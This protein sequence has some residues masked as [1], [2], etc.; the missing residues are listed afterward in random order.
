MHERRFAVTL[1]T[2]EDVPLLPPGDRI[3][4]QQ[5]ES[6]GASVRVA[7]WTDRD[8]D[9]SASSLTVIRSTWDACKRFLEFETWLRRVESQTRICNPVEKILW[10]LE[11]RYLLDLQE[12]GIEI[13]PTV[14]FRAGS[15]VSVKPTDLGWPEVVVKP[16]I[17]AS[18]SAVRRFSV[19]Q[20][21]SPL[22]AHLNAILDRTGALVQRFE[23]TV[24]TLAERS[25]VFIGGEYSHAVRRIPFNTGDTPDSPEFDH[26]ADEAEIAFATRVLAAADCT[27]LPFARVD[28]VPGPAGP[29]LMELELIEPALFLTRNSAA[30]RN[31]ASAIA[32][33]L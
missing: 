17:G 30:P 29:L 21:L 10:N 22:Q 31:L 14:Y 13:I 19:A 12:R 20:E 23:N 7:I 2:C 18:S 3:L 33:L 28:M 11:K 32:A 16:S 27:E 6:L 24:D 25:L 26:E 9:W 8:V 1:V 5:L 4:Q 15:H